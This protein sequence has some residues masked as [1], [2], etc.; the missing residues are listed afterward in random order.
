MLTRRLGQESI[1]N[2]LTELG[3]KSAN[4]WSPNT[5][6]ANDVL[7]MLEK[8]ADPSFTSPTLSEEMLSFMVD[9]NQED[10]IPAALPS[11]VRVAH[12]AGSYEDTYGD[13][14][15]ILL[16]EDGNGAE[17]SFFVVVLAKGTGKD[18]ARGAIHEVSFAAHRLLTGEV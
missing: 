16:E 8:I 17:E 18:E 1:R 12:K 15:I 10:R 9:T 5:T 13:A 11:D 14:G 7:L 4:Y 6:T 2:E 3:A